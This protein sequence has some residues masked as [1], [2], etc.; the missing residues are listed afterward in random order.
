MINQ[1]KAIIDLGTN[2]FNLIIYSV[3]LNDF[4]IH[5]TNKLV[6]KLGAEGFEDGRIHPKAIQRAIS[7]MK[8]HKS[9]LQEYDVRQ[10][11]AFATSGLRS[12]VNG[13]QIADQIY[14]EVGVRVKII[15]G[16]REAELIALGVMAYTNT[17]HT[18]LIMDIGGGSTEFA[19]IQDGV[20][21]WK[22]SYDLGVARM[23]QLFGQHQPMSVS[24]QTS[25]KN[26][27]Q[28]ALPELNEAIGLHNPYQFIGSS[29]S[30]EAFGMMV[31]KML[32]QA[33]KTT[34]ETRIKTSDL[35]QLNRKLI[36]LNYQSKLNFPGLDPM[37][38]EYIVYAGIFIEHVAKLCSADNIYYSDFSLKEG[39]IQASIENTL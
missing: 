26:Y 19:I 10:V 23:V 16:M 1:P 20:V 6:V 25:I 8:Q 13:H 18:A 31:A 15:D 27:L 28:H 21:R 12:A 39:A 38:A 7:A 34:P 35:I 36:T 14:K 22:H 9:S 2:T 3:D 32:N 29:G 30:F 17:Q 11:D 37:R 4:T 33:W 5:F 24:I